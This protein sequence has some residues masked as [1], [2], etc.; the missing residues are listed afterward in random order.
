[1]YISVA[2]AEGCEVTYDKNASKL[3]FLKNIITIVLSNVELF[4]LVFPQRC[5][6]AY[7]DLGMIIGFVVLILFLVGSVCRFQ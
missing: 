7:S 3:C 4:V 2:D 5:A 1:M 6:N